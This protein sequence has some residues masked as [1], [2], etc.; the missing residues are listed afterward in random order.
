[1][2]SMVLLALLQL[3]GSVIVLTPELL[4]VEVDE[5]E[6]MYPRHSPSPPMSVNPVP[7]V[8]EDADRGK[9]NMNGRTS[10]TASKY[11][12]TFCRDVDILKGVPPHIQYISKK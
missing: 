2:T 7:Q 10:K 8:V 3:V 9:E 11:K 12:S 6:T 4:F 5:P 1:M